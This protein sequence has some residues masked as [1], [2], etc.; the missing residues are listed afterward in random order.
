MWEAGGKKEVLF[1][2]AMFLTCSWNFRWTSSHHRCWLDFCAIFSFFFSQVCQKCLL[3]PLFFAGMSQFLLP[4]MHPLPPF[5]P[6]AQISPFPCS[7]S[8]SIALLLSLWLGELQEIRGK[9]ARPAPLT[10]PLLFFS[11]FSFQTRIAFSVFAPFSPLQSFCLLFL[12][13]SLT[14]SSSWKRSSSKSGHKLPV[15]VDVPLQCGRALC[16]NR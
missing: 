7:R 11:P 2:L 12:G 6:L 10:F 4:F 9:K 13:L 1:Y 3:Q 14:C 15:F 8:P 16:I 5:L